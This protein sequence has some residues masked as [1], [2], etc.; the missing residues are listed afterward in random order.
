M[1]LYAMLSGQTC[2]E[3]FALCDKASLVTK[4]GLG[5]G[6]SMK[7]EAHVAFDEEEDL[8][9][10]ELGGDMEGRIE[11]GRRENGEL[12]QRFRTVKGS[13]ALEASAS[14]NLGVLEDNIT[15]FAN[16]LKGKI[17]EKAEGR[18]DSLMPDAVPEALAD[19]AKS[20]LGDTLDDKSNAALGALSGR[21]QEA[22]EKGEDGVLSVEKSRVFAYEE[23]RTITEKTSL[24]SAG[25]HKR[26]LAAYQRVRSFEPENKAEAIDLMHKHK[27]SAECISAILEELK[28]LPANEG[29][30]LELVSGMKASA[31]DA[32]NADP[33]AKLGK[34]SL[35]LTEV[36]VS[37]RETY[38]KAQNLERGPVNMSIQRGFT[39][40]QTRSV[41]A[42][43]GSYE[44]AMKAAQGE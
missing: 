33:K 25:K 4:G 43:I 7:A 1:F 40:T 32:Y 34:A 42:D 29:F 28:E 31:I 3:L 9:A 19:A 6:F 41:A 36:R 26:V 21:L 17:S 24:S 20:K 18:I 44:R 5:A 10:A 37:T 2:S 12:S 38:A 13:L 23:S 14:L 35:E 39:H 30:R 11:W 15:S 16:S 22:G 8:L 27:V